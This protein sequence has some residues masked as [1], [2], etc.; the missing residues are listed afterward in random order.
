[1]AEG[2]QGRRQHRR[3]DRQRAHQLGVFGEGG[4][5]NLDLLPLPIGLLLIA[6]RQLFTIGHSTHP[7]GNFLQLLLRHEIQ[8]V[9]D[10]RSSPFSSRLPHFNRASLER[11]L[12]DVHLRYVFLG[13]ELGA[14]RSERECYVDGVAQYE[15]IAKTP[16]FASGLKRLQK[17]LQRFRIAVL[18]AEKDPI[19]CHRTILVCR[20]LRSAA[21]IQ[22]ILW[23][24][25]LEP[26]TDAETRLMHE[27][28]ISAGDFFIARE[29][30][31]ARAYERRGQKIAYH[32]CSDLETTP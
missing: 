25:S 4:G 20:Q 10:V 6:M 9:A 5:L 18:C 22:H 14:R 11:C 32:E 17:G 21:E 7:W 23:D 12:R 29:T 19:E 27:E 24:G 1:M 28:R 30:L 31:L 16:A 8:V 13:E 2:R 15:R 3:N 26:H